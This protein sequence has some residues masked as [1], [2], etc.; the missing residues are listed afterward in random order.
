M[1]EESGF[2]VTLRDVWEAQ[3]ETNRQVASLVEQLPAHVTATAED[4]DQLRTQMTDHEARVRWLE[5]T[6]WKIVGGFSAVFL[7]TTA[8]EAVYYFTHH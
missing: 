3:Q 5:R 8:L 6:I 1:S 2:I 7:I 4:I